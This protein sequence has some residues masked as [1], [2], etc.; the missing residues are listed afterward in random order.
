MTIALCD[1]NANNLQQAASCIAGWAKKYP[2]HIQ[3]SPFGDSVTLAESI[4]K[5]RY[6][7]IFVL[8]IE[9][10]IYSGIQLSTLIRER[11]PG[12]VIIFLTAYE[13]FSIQGYALGVWR[14]VLKKQMKDELLPALDS[15]YHQALC[16]SRQRT[17]R[18]TS[19]NNIYF[20]PVNEILYIEHCERKSYITTLEHLADK[21]LQD[22]RSLKTLYAELNNKQ[23]IY[24]S[25]SEIVNLNYV[26][27]LDQFDLF[28]TNG[29]KRRVSRAEKSS[30]VNAL[31]E[32][33]EEKI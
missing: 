13:K 24:I 7:D 22:G 10:R 2:T 27:A 4:R 6:F 19:Y 26:R 17:L 14:Y 1:D 20:V 3:L 23:F 12:A 28:L 16:Q 9:M 15:A 32:Y 8:D 5:G 18:V 21:R 11:L 31:H 29:E 30:V 33:L 25:R